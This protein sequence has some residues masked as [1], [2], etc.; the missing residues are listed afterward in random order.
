MAFLE[1]FDDQ[2]RE[3]L[4]SLPYIAGWYIAAS[5]NEGG[6]AAMEAEHAQLEKVIRKKARGLQESAFVHE[7]LV[8]TIKQKDQWS[9]WAKKSKDTLDACKEARKA[10]EETL[11]PR[12]LETYRASVLKIA[13]AVAKSFEEVHESFLYHLQ[14]KVKILL[15][16]LLGKGPEIPA[17]G[18]VHHNISFKEDRALM[19]LAEALGLDEQS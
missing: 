15:N 2:Q 3:L 17:A 4:I 18:N 7:V 6:H 9:G 10:I 11:S 13:V 5:D 12:E 8:E 14:N 16:K 1:K 19:E